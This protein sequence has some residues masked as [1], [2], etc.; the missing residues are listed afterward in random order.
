MAKRDYYEILGVRRE[1]TISEIKK[2]YR[3]LAKK[4]HPD[5]NP[6]DKEAE[7]HFKEV[8]EA[9]EVLSDE[10]KRSAY[11]HYGHAAFGGSNGFGGFGGFGGSSAFADFFED[12]FSSFMGGSSRGASGP[13]RGNDLRKDIE[14]TLEEAFTGVVKTIKIPSHKE[15]SEC[16]GTGSSG[17]SS[18]EYCSMCKGSGRVRQSQG[19]FSIETICPTCEGRGKIIKD[20]CR[21]CGA[22][23]YVKVDKTLEVTIPKGVETGTRMRISGEGDLGINGGSNGDLY[24]FIKVKDHKIFTRSG[25][26]L[27]CSVPISMI[28]ATLGGKVSVPSLD[29]EEEEVEVSAGTQTGSRIKIKEKGMP[30]LNGVSRGNLYIDLNVQTPTRLTSRQIEL[31]KEFE[32][33][34]ENHTPSIGDFLGKVKEFINKVTE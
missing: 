22:T 1:A 30:I 17:G 12:V 5:L 9:Y 27:Y 7:V 31:L 10:D 11:D 29:K 4:Y 3:T 34:G 26:D 16:K 13:Q 8:C 2:S 32:K 33:E 23:G 20:P 18:P 25:N 28:T 14:I 21:K 15:C 19:F 24:L 6:G